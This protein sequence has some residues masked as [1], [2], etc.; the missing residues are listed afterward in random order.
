MGAKEEGSEREV[1]RK[2]RLREGNMY[3]KIKRG[4]YRKTGRKGLRERR[5]SVQWE[6]VV[7]TVEWRREKG[8]GAA[9]N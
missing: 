5:E 2:G 6:W 8:A 3:R 7:G 1:N 4:R 9:L